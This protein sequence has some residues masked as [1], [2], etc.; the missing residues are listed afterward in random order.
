MNRKLFWLIQI[1]SI[2]LHV[3]TWRVTDWATLTSAT[4]FYLSL[5]TIQ[6][7]VVGFA[8]Y[9]RMDTKRLE[10]QLTEER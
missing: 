9:L 8:I 2:I 10:R 4:Y 3:Y 5:L 7:T 1:T 6:L